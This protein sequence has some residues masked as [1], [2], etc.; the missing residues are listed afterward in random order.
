VSLRLVAP[1]H[2]PTLPQCR[3]VG[4][5][6]CC[7][8]LGLETEGDGHGSILRF[9][10][11]PRLN[12]THLYLVQCQKVQLTR[13]SAR[14]AAHE[15]GGPRTWDLGAAARAQLLGEQGV[16]VHAV[17]QNPYFTELTTL[18]LLEP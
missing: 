8:N 7:C 6:V 2:L 5:S 17:H 3:S 4:L 1:D 16:Q 9:E 18:M 13:P 15:C 10:S 14:T 12:P 11:L